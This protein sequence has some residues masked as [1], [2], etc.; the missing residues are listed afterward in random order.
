MLSTSRKFAPGVSN[1]IPCRTSGGRNTSGFGSGNSWD[2]ISLPCGLADNIRDD[3][4]NGRCDSRHDARKSGSHRRA[5]EPVLSR[6]SAKA[7][8]M[9]LVVSSCQDTCCLRRNELT[10]VK[11][12]AS[13]ASKARDITEATACGADASARSVES[14]GR[15][16]RITN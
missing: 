11:R 14:S 5:P 10:V 15:L 6:W 8:P 9:L 13:P 4:T 16:S 2:L 7:R 1:N 3:D 12:M